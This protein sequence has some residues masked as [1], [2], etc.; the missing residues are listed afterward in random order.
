VSNLTKTFNQ[1]YTHG[2]KDASKKSIKCP[3][4]K[5]SFVLAWRQGYDDFKTGKVILNE[6]GIWDLNND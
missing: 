1:A 5:R 4:E 2:V 6:F 3:Y